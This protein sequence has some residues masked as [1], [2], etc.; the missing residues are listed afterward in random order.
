LLALAGLG[1][2]AWAVVD[3]RSR[4]GTLASSA[5]AG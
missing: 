3:A 2:F 1:M 5:A 4:A